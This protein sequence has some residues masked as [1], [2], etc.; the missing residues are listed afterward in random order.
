[1]VPLFPREGEH[2]SERDG[3]CPVTDEGFRAGASA[4]TWVAAGIGFVA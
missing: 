1:M 3:V 4:G 2:G